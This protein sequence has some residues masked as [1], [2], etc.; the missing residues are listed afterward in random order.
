VRIFF[1]HHTSDRVLADALKRAIRSS[2]PGDELFSA[3][4][5]L[6]AGQ[7]W[8]PGLGKSI[9]NADAFL[10]LVGDRLGPYQIIEYNQA[11]ERRAEDPDF[12]LA[13]A[14]AGGAAPGLPSLH[15]IPWI[16]SKTPHLQPAV[17]RI[18]AALHGGAG[19]EPR[20]P[21]RLAAPYRGPE[22][23]REQDAAFFF[24]RETET[25]AII[26]VIATGKRSVITVTGAA[27]VGKSSL[28]EAGVQACLRR[29]RWPDGASSDLA[30]SD[31]RLWPE[32]LADSREWAYL[33][34]RPGDDPIMSLVDA[35]MELWFSRGSSPAR[36]RE[37][38]RE[39]WR[40]LLLDGS[41]G[42]SELIEATQA[43]FSQQLKLAPPRRVALNIDRSEEL[44]SRTPDELRAWFSGLVAAGLRDRRF[45]ALA[46]LRASHYDALRANRL[47]FEA[48]SLFDLPPLGPAEL[49]R[50]LAE[51]ARLL[52]AR[53]DQ[54]E[55]A[56]LIIER[57]GGRRG[58][59]AL[60]SSYAKGQWERMQRRGDG[61]IRWNE[62]VLSA[63]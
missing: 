38:E 42:L 50:A 54:K 35:F 26:E 43:R 63:E 57:A 58:A 29:R 32:T 47:L 51:P 17:D 49:R 15:R 22:A 61:V 53:F 56:D 55:Q 20:E 34:M 45:V 6:K 7:F 31:A 44:Y 12:S 3:P 39:T 9:A 2:S 59:L 10:L 19:D 18:V 8:A 60:L 25:T 28:I 11:L 37:E 21:W 30:E 41:A 40:R 62:E 4:P 14:L 36:L 27:G 24:G 33:T 23:L 13:L 16:E 1:S 48:S 5:R 52:G 46:S